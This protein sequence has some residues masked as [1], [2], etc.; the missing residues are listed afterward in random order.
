MANLKQTSNDLTQIE[1]KIKALVQAM[2]EL[3]GKELITDDKQLESMVE[4][5][6]LQM[7]MLNGTVDKLKISLSGIGSDGKGLSELNK[8]INDVNKQLEAQISL[9]SKLN[10]I[11]GLRV[12]IPTTLSQDNKA[13]NN[14]SLADEMSRARFEH[15]KSYVGNQEAISGQSMPLQSQLDYYKQAIKGF[16]QGSNEQYLRCRDKLSNRLKLRQ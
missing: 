4:H 1:K 11:G 3:K 14:Q 9:I 12:S 7:K 5:S 6:A 15:V 16:E 8:K 10:S 13:K 2:D